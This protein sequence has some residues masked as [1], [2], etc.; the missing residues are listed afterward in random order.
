MDAEG[1]KALANLPNRSELQGMIL[2]LSRSPGAN[3]AG[4][5]VGPGGIIAGCIKSLVDKLEE[6][7]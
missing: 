1:V 5:V 7:A 4:A 3:V 6:A 2:L